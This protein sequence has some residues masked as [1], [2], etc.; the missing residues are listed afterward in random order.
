MIVALFPDNNIADFRTKVE[1]GRRI[2]QFDL[3]DESL[4][5]PLEVGDVILIERVTGRGGVF[6]KVQ[7]ECG[8]VC[9]NSNTIRL[10]GFEVGFT[11]K[12]KGE[13]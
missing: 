10:I 1:F 11:R 12:C 7:I 13:K 3:R 8:F 9:P 4:F 5:F 2:V 6:V